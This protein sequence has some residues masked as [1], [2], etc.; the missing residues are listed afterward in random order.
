MR[1]L[2]RLFLAVT[3]A[4]LGGCG[5]GPKSA[6]PSAD[7]SA[8]GAPAFTLKDIHGKKVSLSDFRGK[9]VFL[10]F[11]ATWCPPC[12]FSIP[13]IEDLHRE[14]APRGLN[15]VGISLD[16]DPSVVPEF[17]K[18]NGMNYTVLLGAGSDV[19]DRY[20]VRGIPAMYL[21]DKKGNIVRRWI[22]FDPRLREEW[23]AA[24]DALLKS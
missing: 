10:D 5:A 1:R 20:Q 9:A 16:E 12:R 8:T 18:E 15:I 6:S 19:A 24:V 7:P 11:W 21:I 23:R 13:A 2:R 17:V 3:L 4:A 22:G 14:F